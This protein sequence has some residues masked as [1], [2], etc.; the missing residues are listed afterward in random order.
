MIFTSLILIHVLIVSKANSLQKI[1]NKATNMCNDVLQLIH[2]NICG[3]ITP[4]TM[5]GYRYFITFI[6]DFSRFGWIDLLQDKSCSLEAF[7]SFKTTI[8]LKTGKKNKCVRLDRGG[9]YY[10]YYNETTRNPRPFA[11]FLYECGIKAQYTMPDTLG[12]NRVAKR[13]PNKLMSKTPYEQMAGRKLSLRHFHVWGCKG[14]VRPYNPQQ[15]KL[16]LK[17]VSNFFIG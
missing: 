6:Y 17:I 7:K 12:Q 13:L 11:R 10:G 8:E 16:D 3:Q 15:K 5:G 14:E 2:T 9:E 1:I 4:T